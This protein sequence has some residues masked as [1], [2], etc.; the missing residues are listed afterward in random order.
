MAELTSQVTFR[1]SD[2]MY[3]RI[4]E[5]AKEERRKPNEVARAL[6]ERGEAAYTSDGRLFEP[7]AGE[8]QPRAVALKIVGRVSGGKPIEPI[9]HH[10]EIMVLS[11]DIAGIKK[12]RAL[13]VVGDSM[14]DANVMDGDII[15]VGDC[16][17]PINKI[18]VAYIEE[19]GT[20]GATLKWWRQKGQSVTLEPA[21]PDYKPFTYPAKKL[22]WYGALAGVIRT[23][24]LSE[25][26]GRSEADAA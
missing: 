4:G 26:A 13:R 5:I 1:V 21:N 24:P 2:K 18:V 23:I 8:S 15:L 3:Q 7:G 14:R 12:A 11:T 10:E 22:R 17:S 16:E 9:E 25:V 6:L 20:L 19:K